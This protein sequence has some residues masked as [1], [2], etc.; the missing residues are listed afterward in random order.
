M[1][2]GAPCDRVRLLWLLEAVV[3]VVVRPVV[4]TCVYGRVVE[5]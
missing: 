3:S 2:R 5:R 4:L 1:Y